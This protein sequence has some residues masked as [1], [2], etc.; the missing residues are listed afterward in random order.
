MTSAE[1]FAAAARTHLSQPLADRWIELLRP[2][3]EFPYPDPDEP[4]EPERVALRRGGDP[5][6]PDEVDWPTVEG[7]GPLMFMADMDCAAVAAA[8]GV[9]LL[10]TEG[11][12]LFFYG[13]H[14]DRFPE[15]WMGR[16]S[17]RWTAWEQGRVIYLPP[18]LERKPRRQPQEPDPDDW[19]DPIEPQD[20][21][22][23]LIST[24]PSAASELIEHNFGNGVK[25]QYDSH[26][27]AVLQA[28]GPATLPPGAEFELW[29]SDFESAVNDDWGYCYT[30]GYAHPC[31]RPV[32]LETAVA[33]LGDGTKMSDERA[34]E[35][36]G[37]WRLLFQDGW[38]AGDMI[39]Y[40]MIREDDL[41]A[42][43]FDRVWFGQQR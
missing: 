41:A 16:D 10:P 3:I 42:G 30:G 19:L 13:G 25:A 11:S 24:P 37:H 34:L 28:G 43:R 36:A 39:L 35:E 6:L 4:V 21:C 23:V 38:E 31:Q 12:L 27:A 7:Y 29:D 40:W 26:W 20:S 32:E 22:A 18:G 33:A 2:A 17:Q 1:E 5:L 9:E 15:R 14:P 8:G